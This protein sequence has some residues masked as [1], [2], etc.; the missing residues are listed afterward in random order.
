MPWPHTDSLVKPMQK[1]NGDSNAHQQRPL[2][3]SK[4][5]PIWPSLSFAY[6]SS[7]CSS[8]FLGLTQDLLQNQEIQNP[9]RKTNIVPNEASTPNTIVRE[10]KTTTRTTTKTI[11]N[12]E[13]TTIPTTAESDERK[14]KLLIQP[15]Y[16]NRPQLSVYV[17]ERRN[18]IIRIIACVLTSTFNSPTFSNNKVPCLFLFL[19]YLFFFLT[20]TIIGVMFCVFF[21]VAPAKTNP[22]S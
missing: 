17:E 21:S 2:V 22:I 6:S 18:G 14:R 15:E 11:T 1:S 19:I 13:T 20:K 12:T 9:G 4:S 16:D 5:L 8:S 3:T 10:S 7:F